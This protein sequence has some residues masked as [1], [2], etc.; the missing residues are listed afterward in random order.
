M[1]TQRILT[2]LAALTLTVGG[3][4]L[5]S[6]K[7][8]SKTTT[9]PSK[10]AATTGQGVGQAPIQHDSFGNVIPQNSGDAAGAK[11][12]TTTPAEPP[13]IRKFEVGK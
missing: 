12:N 11:T 10:P 9:T 4:F 2:A 1:R 8:Q 7:A 3:M 13:V 6:A 5:D